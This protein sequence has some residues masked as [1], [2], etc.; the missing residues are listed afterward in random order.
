MVDT[1]DS[2]AAKN[3][4][5]EDDGAIFPWNNKC[6][7]GVVV[8]PFADEKSRERFALLKWH[9][10]NDVVDTTD[11]D[12]GFFFKYGFFTSDVVDL[13]VRLF[14]LTRWRSVVWGVL[15]WRNKSTHNGKL[16]YF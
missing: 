7:V 15:S 9:V 14:A 5:R 3:W 16:K 4:W 6:V 10:D 2:D 8:V 1:D 13:T 12:D 11:D